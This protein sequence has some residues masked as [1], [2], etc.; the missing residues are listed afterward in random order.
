LLESTKIDAIEVA[1]SAEPAMKS[2]CSGIEIDRTEHQRK[3]SSSSGRNFDRDS[4][5]K[6]PI[7]VAAIHDFPRISTKLG[8]EIHFKDDRQ[9][10][11]SLISRGLDPSSNTSIIFPLTLKAQ[12]PNDFDE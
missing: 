2:T 8:M 10:Q 7:R 9:K 6:R 1:E 11:L 12:S 3:H 5:V 4:I